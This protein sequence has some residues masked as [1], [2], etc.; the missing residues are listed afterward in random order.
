MGQQNRILP[1]SAVSQDIAKPHRKACGIPHC[2][3][4]NLSLQT[5]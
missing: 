1:A 2:A 3:R 4:R 5:M